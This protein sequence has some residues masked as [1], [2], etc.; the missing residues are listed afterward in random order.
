MILYGHKC[1]TTREELDQ[2]LMQ[3]QLQSFFPILNG[4]KSRNMP[5]IFS[6]NA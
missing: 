2:Q 6:D 3:E 1:R 4:D 5:V